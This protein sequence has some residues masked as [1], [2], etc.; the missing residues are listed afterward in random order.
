MILVREKAGRF[1]DLIAVGST[2][3]SSANKGAS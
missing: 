1:H 3:V 2:L